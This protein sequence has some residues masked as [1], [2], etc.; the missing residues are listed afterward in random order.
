MPDGRPLLPR[1][2]MPRVSVPGRASRTA[3]EPTPTTKQVQPAKEANESQAAAT[4]G[5]EPQVAATKEAEPKDAQ[6]AAAKPGPS[7]PEPNLQERIEGLQG[8]VAEL[9]RKQARVTYFGAL[10]L[11][12]ALGA[13]G[14][15]LYF[16]LTAHSDSATKSD[17]DALTNRVNSLQGAVT[18]NSKDT[19]NAINTSIAQ[20]QQ[21]LG[22]LQKQ[23][24]QAAANISTL[25]SQ[26]ASGALNKKA[27]PGVTPTT[28][29]AATTT[30][31]PNAKNP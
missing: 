20:L 3:S 28:P 15:A 17:L 9:E 18:K 14:A 13:A 26:V 2:R 5:T 16:G 8:W 29:G 7:R 24:A 1:I 12:L 19:Q 21:S 25:Q 22:N 11:L 4:K 23:Q 30:T 27:T 31:T 6:P 10:A